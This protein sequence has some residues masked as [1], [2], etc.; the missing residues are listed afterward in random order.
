MPAYAVLGAQWGD[1]GKGKIIDYLASKANIVARFSGGN[2][3]GHTV[4][5]DLGHFSLHLIPCGIFQDGVMNVIGNGVVVNP[6]ELIEEMEVLKSSGLSLDGKL[7]I[8]E[9]AHLI[10]PYHIVLDN[11]T[12]KSKGNSA[13]GTTGKGIGPAY[14]DKTSRTG[15]R[16]ADLLDMSG[17]KDRLE[18]VME[19][20]NAV[21]TKI[22]GGDPVC[23]DD[24]Y[25]K[26]KIWA[27]T[28]GSYIGPT[29][30]FVNESLDNGGNVVLEGAQGILL[31]LDHG[32]Y[33]YVTSSNPTIGGVST[34]LGIQPRHIS[35]VLGIF[36]AYNTRV[37]SGPFPS[38]L[39]DSTAEKI[40]TIANEF[41][42][43]TGRP[44]RV[45]WFDGVAAAYSTR[46]NGYSSAV[47]T[48]LDVLDGF[49]ELKV[50]V[51]Y[52]LDG[53][54][55]QELPG[56][57]SALGRCKPVYETLEGWTTPTAGVS[58]IKTLPHAAKKYIARLEQLIGCPISIISTGPHRDQTIM[59]E[60][61]I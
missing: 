27:D 29:G 38:E 33:P 10:M 60:S 3:A 22:Y 59:P 17:L 20:S 51:A 39:L 36:K 44:R 12:E 61:V 24:L 56:G 45:G 15:I 42:T 50:C 26:C 11:L 13:I 55:I 14:S 43:T 34:G 7:M 31:D 30:K 47:I 4:I 40:R 54:L 2:N 18:N 57:V 16:A 23:L 48:R 21:I 8:S 6:D 32:T 58:D 1:E 9:R 46:I 28:L 35:S 25:Q 53:K 5:N 49:E 19:Y 37:G 41:G 52:D